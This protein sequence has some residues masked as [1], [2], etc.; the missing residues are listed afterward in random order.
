MVQDKKKL[1]VT[2]ALGISD[3]RSE[4]VIQPKMSELWKQVNAKHEVI[5]GLEKMKGVT[6]KEKLLIALFLGE[7]IQ[8]NC[9]KHE[10]LSALSRSLGFSEEKE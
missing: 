7:R 6:I 8:E 4:E 9:H 1:T 2:K 3:K 10:L 5:T